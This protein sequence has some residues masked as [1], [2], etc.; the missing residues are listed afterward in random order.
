MGWVR[1]ELATPE[2]RVEGLIVAHEF[3]DRLHYAVSA[4][5]GLALLRYEVSFS[6]RPARRVSTTIEPS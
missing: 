1:S 4:V 2:Q 5:P 6:V 3:D